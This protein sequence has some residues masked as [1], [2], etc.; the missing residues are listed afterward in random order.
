[1]YEILKG[2]LEDK[3]KFEIKI[4]LEG[5]IQRWELFLENIIN[6]GFSFKIYFRIR[7]IIVLEINPIK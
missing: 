4:F 2:L 7:I 3:F 5:I 1:M 6:L